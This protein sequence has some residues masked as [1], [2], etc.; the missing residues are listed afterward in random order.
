MSDK[1][2]KV[3]GISKVIP[4]PSVGTLVR[5]LQPP[6]RTRSHSHR[7]PRRR[8]RDPHVSVGTKSAGRGFCNVPRNIKES[9]IRWVSGGIEN[10]PRAHPTVVAEIHSITVT[11]SK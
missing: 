11:A 2:S 10:H 1:N 9:L 3:H 4:I 5:V 8:L 7:I 6:M